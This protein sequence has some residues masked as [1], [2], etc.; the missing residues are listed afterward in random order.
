MG[1]DEHFR[2]NGETLVCRPP[3]QGGGAK[4]RGVSALRAFRYSSPN[5]IGEAVAALGERSRALA[6]GTDLITLMKADIAAPDELINVKPLLPRGIEALPAGPRDRAAPPPAPN[7]AP[8][9]GGAGRP[10][11]APGGWPRPAP[12]APPP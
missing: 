8:P 5:T 1:S 9:P 11:P 6:G 10:A 3:D 12:P 4:R 2:T 7:P